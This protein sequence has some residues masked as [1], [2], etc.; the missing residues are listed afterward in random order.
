MIT[1]V[2]RST[3]NEGYRKSLPILDRREDLP[4]DAFTVMVRDLQGGR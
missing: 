1:M 4:E 3:G 2:E